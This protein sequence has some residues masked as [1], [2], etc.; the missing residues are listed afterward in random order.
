M[1]PNLKGK[2]IVYLT[3]GA[4]GMYC[5]SCMRD[6]AVAAELIRQGINIT[7]LP[8]YTPIRTD[9]DD[10]SVEKVFFGGVNVFLHLP[11]R[12]VEA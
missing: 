12:R 8:L 9:E 6:N 10:V 4:A 2:H 5:G 11:A 1:N 7:L 3:A